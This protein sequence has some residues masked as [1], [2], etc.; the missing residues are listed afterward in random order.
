MS[1]LIYYSKVSSVDKWCCIQISVKIIA[2][3][4]RY[5]TGLSP[6]RVDVLLGYVRIAIRA[7]YSVRRGAVAFTFILSWFS[8]ACQVVR[9]LAV[10]AC[11]AWE[12]YEVTSLPPKG[13]RDYGMQSRDLVMP[14][15]H[16]CATY[17]LV[18]KSHG[19]CRKAAVSDSNLLRHDEIKC[20]STYMEFYFRINISH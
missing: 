20:E 7:S 15:I 12:F 11:W 3:V 2:S 10:V 4:V 1:S 6:F 13:S 8:V 9:A 5:D 14:S 18:V 17:S 16:A 19:G